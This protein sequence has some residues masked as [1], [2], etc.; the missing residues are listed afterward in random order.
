[1]AP[2]TQEVV[3]MDV[4]AWGRLNDM[5][6]GCAL[7][8]F[9]RAG[10][11]VAAGADRAE[12]QSE[13]TNVAVLGFG[14][15]QMRGAVLLAASDELLVSSFPKPAVRGGLD[16]DAL[17][18]WSGE[19]LNQ[20]VGRVKA[21]LGKHG[22]IIEPGTPTTISGVAVRVG[23]ATRNAHCVPHKFQ[24]EHDAFIVRFE[25]LAEPGTELSEQPDESR[26]AGDPGDFLIF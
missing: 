25:A 19:L 1:M 24:V 14:G 21:E 5:V 16:R 2:A 4:S 6:V 9:Q 17:L 22:V 13:L 26:T 3:H 23:A 20:L 18:D 7:D 15:R 12:L 11:A 8:T 10:V